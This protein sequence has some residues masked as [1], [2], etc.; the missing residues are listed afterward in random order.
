MMYSILPGEAAM[1]AMFRLFVWLLLTV[2]C[3]IAVAEGLAAGIELAPNYPPRNSH[4]RPVTG[5]H[6]LT[7]LD[8][9]TP[10]D[11]AG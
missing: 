9:C 3:L 2:P 1:L 10:L 7:L 6:A 5:H 8:A 4:G 11:C